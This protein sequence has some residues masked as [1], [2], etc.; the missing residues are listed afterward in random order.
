[1][2][3]E[4]L[5]FATVILTYFLIVFGGYVASS[6]SGMGCGPEWPLCNGE[7]IPELSGD[8][9][10]EFGHR[11]IGAV[12]FILTIILFAKVRKENNQLANKVANWM[13]SLLT[14]Q[15]I[16]GAIVV[17]Y[18]LPS[19][20]ITL[21]LLIAMIFLAMLIW[22]W[23]YKDP[24]ASFKHNHGIA[25]K[26]H[27]NILITL[28]FITIGIGAFIKHQHYGLACGW[29]DCGNTMLPGSLPELLQF[30]HRLLA[31]I[32]SLY[33]LFI[34]YKAF[35][36]NYIALKSRMILALLVVFTQLIIG[37]MTIVSFISLSFA[38]LHLAAA[39]LLFAILAEA[40]I[41]IGK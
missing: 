35:S 25:L 37:I 15:L 7:V 16:M 32:S 30:I 12:L 27:L 39:A 33:I 20:I 21:H 23:R 2:S 3:K 38:V 36:I 17:F 11:V 26:K 19:S 40:R 28:L 41:T 34:A 31:L 6:E 5:A 9:L 29:L 13:L 18:H 8:T 24:S 14:L 4:R 22:F 10:I 1:M